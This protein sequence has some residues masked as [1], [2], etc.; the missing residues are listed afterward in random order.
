MRKFTTQCDDIVFVKKDHDYNA[1]GIDIG[2]YFPFDQ[3]SC[4]HDII[5]KTNRLRALLTSGKIPKNESVED[6]FKDLFN[7]VR[8]GYA[9]LK[10]RGVI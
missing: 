2:D 8:I 1:A 9:I 10:S 4:M 6:N 7:Y 3:Y 5:K